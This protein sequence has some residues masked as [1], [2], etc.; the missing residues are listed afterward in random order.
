MKFGLECAGMLNEI[1]KGHVPEPPLAHEDVGWKAWE[2]HIDLVGYFV[3]RSN[4]RYI[5]DKSGLY[6]PA[7][8]FG[9]SLL[10][11]GTV[12]EKGWK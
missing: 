8:L 1:V 11:P 5:Q 10:G 4:R 3:E 9:N 7:D 12:D 2:K 6:V